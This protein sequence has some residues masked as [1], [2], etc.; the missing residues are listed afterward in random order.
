MVYFI[1]K[2]FHFQNFVYQ[3]HVLQK[4]K[5]LFKVHTSSR[6]QNEGISTFTLFEFP[7]L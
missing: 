4:S 7:N 1:W 3:L 6:A 5:D 2:H